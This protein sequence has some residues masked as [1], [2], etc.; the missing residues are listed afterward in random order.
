MFFFRQPCML[1]ARSAERRH[2]AV[3]WRRLS[4]RESLCFG[5]VMERRP[6]VGER[7]SVGWV[8]GARELYRQTP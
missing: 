7:G 1:R 8:V 4:R 3:V 6:R 2:F 5:F